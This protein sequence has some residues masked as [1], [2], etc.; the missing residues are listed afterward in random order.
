MAAEPPEAM[1][2]AGMQMHQA[3]RLAEAEK[4]Y[5]SVL[6]RHPRH[7]DALYLLGLIAMASGKPQRGADLLARAIG[8]NPDFAPAYC[9]LGIALAALK[10]PEEALVRFDAAVARQPDLADAWY[11]RG[12]VLKDLGRPDAAVE[13]FDTALTLR[14]DDVEAL[15]NRGLALVAIGKFPEALRDFEHAIALQPGF[16]P[17]HCNIGM[18]YSRLRKPFEALEALDRAVGLQTDFAEAWCNRG[19]ALHELGRIEE[20]VASFDRSIALRPDLAEAHFGRALSLLLLGR[21]PE[22]FKEHE[23]RF[24][25]PDA[26]QPRAFPQKPFL[27]GTSLA[28][29]TLFIYPELYLGDMVQFCRYATVAIDSGVKVVM[30]VQRPLRHLLATL[31]PAIEWISEHETPPRIDLHCPLLSLPLAFGTTIDTIPAAMPYLHADPARASWWRGRFGSGLKIGICWQGHPARAEL[32][33]SFPLS[34]FEPLARLPGVRLISLQT[35]AGLEQLAGLPA[36]IEVEHFDDTSDHGMRPFTELAAM[37]ANVN[38]VITTDTVVAHVAGAMGRPAWV[39]LK[40]VADWRWGR[41]G[42]RTQWYPTLRLFR[43]KQRGDWEGVFQEVA[44]TLQHG[45]DQ[46]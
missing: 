46:L 32:N 13:S 1:L 6:Q 19:D 17:A 11:N 3:G 29:R 28:G 20:A 10:R 9:N 16:V 26:P 43:Q 30:A 2:A 38:V 7:A 14:P 39:V 45:R 12:V 40:H 27:G 34:A 37:I 15:N 36:G 23:W 35:G 25:R 42:D 31:H 8:L 4:L 41:S 24:R 33:R 22:G 44:T 21:Y 5:R 18:V